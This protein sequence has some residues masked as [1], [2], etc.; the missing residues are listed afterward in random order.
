[1]DLQIITRM[2]LGEAKLLLRPGHYS[3]AY[4]L[5]GYIV[6]CSLKS[7]IA[8][9]SRRYEFPDRR[10]ASDCHTHDLV[11]LVRLAGLD[12]ILHAEMN[13]NLAFSANWSIIKDWKETCRYASRTEQ[14][15]KDIISAIASRKHGFLKWVRSHW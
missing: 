7:C 3:G 6:E 14:E 10:R 12:S 5:A 2:R 8:R 9:Q 4:Y 1:M 13:A 15:A 11:S